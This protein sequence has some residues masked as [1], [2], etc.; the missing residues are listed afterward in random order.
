MRT[1]QPQYGSYGFL[2][3]AFTNGN[4]ESRKNEV[5]TWGF[6]MDQKP[7]PRLNWT[8]ES[9]FAPAGTPVGAGQMEHFL[10]FSN[11]GGVDYRP[12]SWLF[13]PQTNNLVMDLAIDNI[14]LLNVERS[15]QYGYQYPGGIILYPGA[16]F[17]GSHIGDTTGNRAVAN[18]AEL[19]RLKVMSTSGDSRFYSEFQFPWTN[20]ARS[21]TV[22]DVS[23]TLGVVSGSIGAD[24]CLKFVNGAIV[25]AGGSCVAGPNVT[26]A[27]TANL[28]ANSPATVPSAPYT[29]IQMKA[30]DGTTVYVPAWR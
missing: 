16:V 8:M 27:R 21:V 26:G 5:M 2:Q 11:T 17:R 20:A 18:I 15:V 19:T 24:H 13:R 22:P 6:N 28:G 30:A 12:L 10:S 4:G 3:G 7:G 9:N 1:S 14:N 29:W 23:G 25:S